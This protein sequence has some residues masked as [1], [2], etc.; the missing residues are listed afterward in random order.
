MY[1][2]TEDTEQ[3]KMLAAS[4][5]VTGSIGRT[6]A[7]YRLRVVLAFL[8]QPAS[9]RLTLDSAGGRHQEASTRPQGA[10]STPVWKGRQP[11]HSRSDSARGRDYRPVDPP[12]AVEVLHNGRWCPG[13]RLRDGL[14]LRY[15]PLVD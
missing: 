4:R 15:D 9:A 8:S 11:C 3:P 13:V 7:R 12:K 6:A 1:L 2:R 5:N 14:V 10:S